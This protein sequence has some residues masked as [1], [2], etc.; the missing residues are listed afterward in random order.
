MRSDEFKVLLVIQMITLFLVIILFVNNMKKENTSVA[1]VN[2]IA[3]SNMIKGGN[4]SVQISSKNDYIFGDTTASNFLMIFS[5]YNCEF[6]R[7]FYKHVFDSLNRDYV[8]AGKLKIICKDLIGPEDRMGMLM[9]KVAEVARQTNHFPQVHDLL[10]N[11]P[12]PTDS[13]AAVKLALKG[14]ISEADLK[15]KLNSEETLSKLRKDYDDAKSLN[16]NATPSFV[17]NGKVHVGYLTYADISS[18]LGVPAGGVSDKSC[19]VSH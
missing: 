18:K 16:I 2:A 19:E 5:R 11:E 10:I 3:A 4:E 15:T 7:Y 13:L 6:C 8:H 17:F 12:E 1:G 9:A 14:G